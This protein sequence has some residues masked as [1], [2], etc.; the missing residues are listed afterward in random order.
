MFE[1]WEWFHQSVMS[2][3]SWTEKNRKK[4][5][6][7]GELCSIFIATVLEHIYCIFIPEIELARVAAT[8]LVRKSGTN[9]S[10]QIKMIEPD[11]AICKLT[12][13]E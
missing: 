10:L 11:K 2:R 6:K 5:G 7:A 13:Q 3:K 1:T 8:K 9:I 12:F 4:W